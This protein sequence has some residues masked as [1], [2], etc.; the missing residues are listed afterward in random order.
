MRL[1]TGL[2]F[3]KNSPCLLNIKDLRVLLFWGQENPHLSGWTILDPVAKRGS[4]KLK[5]HTG[6]GPPCLPHPKHTPSSSTDK[7]AVVHLTDEGTG[8]RAVPPARSQAQRQ[9]RDSA[10]VHP[11]T[12]NQLTSGKGFTVALS[13]KGAAALSNLSENEIKNCKVHPGFL[14]N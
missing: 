6:H 12:P 11:W 3:N 4:Y 14:K 1:G 7:R 13:D 10:V 9:S 5:A 8:Q 2:L